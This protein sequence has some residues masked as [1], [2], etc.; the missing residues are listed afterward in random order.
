MCWS[1][2]GLH[3]GTAIMPS[4]RWC[5]QQGEV[6]ICR[7]P[8]ANLIKHSKHTVY[9]LLIVQSRDYEQS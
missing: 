8:G 2:N 5:T 3:I 9:I 4:I 1:Q 6:I 7:L